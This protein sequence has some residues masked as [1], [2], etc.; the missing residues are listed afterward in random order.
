MSISVARIQ[1]TKRN[2]APA[3]PRARNQQP[4][5]PVRQSG[6]RAFRLRGQSG[7][8]VGA[9]TLAVGLWLASGPVATAQQNVIDTPNAFGTLRTI[10]IDGNPLDHTNPFFQSLGTNGRSCSSCHVASSAWTIT[11]TELQQRFQS[12]AGLDPIFRTN[13]GSNS[14]N[15]NVSTVNTRRKAYSMLLNKG[16]IRIGL[17]VPAGAEFALVRVDDPY[18]FASAS[19]LSLF[20]RP[21]PATNLRFLTAVMWDG[22]ESFAPMG[23]TP[24]LSTATRRPGRGL[25]LFNDLKH[26]ANDATLTHAQGAA[27]LTDDLA[28]AIV[29][30]RAEPRDGPAEVSHR[31][32]ALDVGGA[33]EGRPSS[34][35]SPSTSRS[36]TSSGRISGVNRSSRTR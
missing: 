20:R 8:C 29:A 4:A 22:R 31:V 17:P 13:D 12:T 5:C 35:A 2:S 15:A 11:P 28:Q 21:L 26:Q 36:T 3:R 7:L 30:V 18:H 10:T 9:R 27:A 24:I 32:G 33:R 25:A 34:P 1:P 14:P 19:E 23:T 6:A 16:V